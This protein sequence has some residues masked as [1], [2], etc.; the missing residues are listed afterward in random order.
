MNVNCTFPSF[1]RPAEGDETLFR[2]MVGAEIVRIG[3]PSNGGLE[4][5]G[6][7]IDYRLPA[8]GMTRRA[9]FEFNELGLWPVWEGFL[10][11]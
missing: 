11:S 8:D 1:F 4:G 9:V 7:I 5:G 3:S 2:Q 6:L 10:P